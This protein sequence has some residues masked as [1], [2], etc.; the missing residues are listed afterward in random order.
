MPEDEKTLDTGGVEELKE[1]YIASLLA[2]N[3]A[4]KGRFPTET[5][6]TIHIGGG[7]P[8]QLGEARLFLLIDTL[9]ETRGVETLEELTIEL[10]PDPIDEVVA[11]VDSCQKKYAHLYRLRFSFGIQTFDDEILKS[12]KRWYTFEGIQEFLRKLQKIKQLTTVYN[13]DF[14]GFGKVKKWKLRDETRMK[15]FTSIAKSAVIDGFSLYTLELTPGSNRYYEDKHAPA[16]QKIYGDNDQLAE[17]FDI[18]SGILTN[19]G[20]RRYELSNFAKMSKRSIHNMVYWTMQ[21]Y[22]GLWINASSFLPSALAEQV[23]ELMD[24]KNIDTKEWLKGVRFKNTS[25]RKDYL[26]NAWIDKNSIE[27]LDEHT[28]R[29]EQAFLS[30]RTDQ[31]LIYDSTIAE[32]LFV[33]D[34]QTHLQEWQDEGFLV[35]TDM[36][37]ILTSKGLDVYNTIVTDLF[38]DI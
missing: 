4:W 30:L 21:P 36:K 7:T 26:A 29:N 2:E 35:F 9:L 17:E 18:L 5:V 19:A 32:E 14:I 37:I 33:P 1:K 34:Y 16:M 11:F 3:M 28:Y 12:S 15:F 22:I 38:K 13:L 10:N 6:R 24:K 20:Y 31:G 8:F 25:H 23:D 27:Y